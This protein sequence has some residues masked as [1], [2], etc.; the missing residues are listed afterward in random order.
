M[1]NRNRQWERNITLLPFRW[2][3]IDAMTILI[4]HLQLEQM[5]SASLSFVFFCT[6]VLAFRVSQKRRTTFIK[7]SMW[8]A[9][10]CLVYSKRN[11]TIYFTQFTYNVTLNMC[12]LTKNEKP[13]H[14]P[15]M[16]RKERKRG[17]EIEWELMAKLIENILEYWMNN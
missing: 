8:W 2:L 7:N 14:L 6:F 12:I 11:A 10:E 16:K 17:K 5:S 1:K 15:K 13:L 4:N 9:R 3:L